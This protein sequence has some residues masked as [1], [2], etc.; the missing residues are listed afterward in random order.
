[1]SL[2]LA[3]SLPCAAAPTVNADQSSSRYNR[4]NDAGSRSQQPVAVVG[5]RIGG[6]G[7]VT[8]A[9]GL[10]AGWRVA[11]RDGHR[12]GRGSARGDNGEVQ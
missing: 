4:A 10:E 5:A 9:A 8:S 2:Q 11:Q 7:G 6:G 12:Q 1:M 3:T